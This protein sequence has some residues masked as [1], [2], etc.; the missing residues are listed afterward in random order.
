MANGRR[1]RA[2]LDLIAALV[3]G[4]RHHARTQEALDKLGEVVVAPHGFYDG[5]DRVAVM[6]YFEPVEGHDLDTGE[7]VYDE[8][9]ERLAADLRA[10]GITCTLEN[11]YVLDPASGRLV[12]A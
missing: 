7:F 9:L 12:P 4:A 8:A 10:E 11:N 3:A 6:G 5:P 1:L 2:E